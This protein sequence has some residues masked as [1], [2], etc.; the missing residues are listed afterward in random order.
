MKKILLI[1]LFL[2]FVNIVVAQED[3][4]YNSEALEINLKVGSEIVIKPTASEYNIKY[5]IVNISFAP[6]DDINQKILKFETEPGGK[7]ENNALNFRFENPTERNLYFNYDADIRIYNRI[8]SVR[9]KIPFPIGGVPEEL[10]MYSQSA[11]IINSDDKDIIELASRLVEGENDLFVAV[12]KIAAWT[13]NNINYNLSTLTAEVNQKASWVLE[14]RQGVCDE[15]T[16]LFIAM[17]RAVGIPAKFISGIS[18]TNSPLFPEQWGSHGWAEVYFPDVGWVPFDVTYGEFGYVDPTH[19][20]LNEGVDSDEASTQY[21]WLGRNADLDTRSLDVKA[22]LINI[23]GR[24]AKPVSIKAN[25]LKGNIGFGSYNIVEAQLENLKDYYVS[26]E[27][28]LS[29]TKEL[30]VSGDNIKEVLLLP[31]EK[32]SVYWLLKVTDDLEKNFIYTFPVI[33]SSLRNFTSEVS[34]KA[35]ENDIF[36]SLEEMEEILNQKEEEVIKIYSRNV[37][38]DCDVSENE[39]Y[40]YEDALIICNVKNVG[41]VFLKDLDVCYNECK[42]IDLGIGRSDK[43]NFTVEEDSGKKDIIIKASNVD[44]SKTTNVEFNI[45]DK[46]LIKIINVKNPY[47]VS[48][49]DSFEVEFELSKASESNPL[50]VDIDF[51]Q[52]SFTKTWNIKEFFEGRKF[53]VKLDGNSLKAGKNDFSILVKYKDGNNRDY[54]S[55]AS[56]DIDLVN[57]NLWQKVQIAFL[58]SNK[59]LENLSV[60]TSILLIAGIGIAFIVVVMFVFRK[61]G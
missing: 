55:F 35:S 29:R 53:I 33:V 6:E 43:V 40:D 47:N 31:N 59:T 41:N 46:P 3:W 38:L 27:I 32:K 34:F 15:L 36:Y 12:H 44:V 54:E 1:I 23:I 7:I 49:E 16:S 13:K 57:V 5:V 19:I 61:R 2:V 48:F 60:K 50:D 58:Q 37:K 17:L 14:N 51:E 30:E 52:N 45:L 9:E 8:I 39:F 4:Y 56:F 25:I 24:T 28:F 18:F 26:T 11:N 21:R 42:K 10:K 20:K 22:N